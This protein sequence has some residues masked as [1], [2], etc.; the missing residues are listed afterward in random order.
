MHKEVKSLILLIAVVVIIVFFLNFVMNLISSNGKEMIYNI[1]DKL[2]AKGYDKT[3]KKEGED[4]NKFI[5]YPGFMIL[6]PK[7]WRENP[8]MVGVDAII[9]NTK[10]EFNND[11]ER[12]IN[13]QTNYVVSHESFDSDTTF[14][15]FIVEYLLH[16]RNTFENIEIVSQKSHIVN[17]R[18]AYLIE[19]LAKQNNVDYHIYFGLIEGIN[20]NAWIVTF[21]TL[22]SKREEYKPHFETIFNEFK[23]KRIIES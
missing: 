18:S 6:I 15:S 12:N 7:G 20:D 1:N 2:I 3:Y 9:S 23:V 10:E 8:P 14:K 4:S 5:E 13:F 16:I 17:K 19:G 21:S 11:N 22:E